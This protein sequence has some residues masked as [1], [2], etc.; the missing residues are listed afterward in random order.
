MEAG[1]NDVGS[2]VQAVRPGLGHPL[3]LEQIHLDQPFAFDI[4]QPTRLETISRS[5]QGM[6]CLRE[7]NL[8]GHTMGFHPGGRVHRIAPEV[9]GEFLL[10]DHPSNHRTGMEPNP[11]LQGLTR[12]A[13]MTCNHLLH[14]ERHF[15]HLLSM[16]KAS[17]RHT[18]HRHVSITNGFDFLGLIHTETK[19]GGL[20]WTV[21]DASLL[22]ATAFDDFS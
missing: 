20:A 14:P 22:L 12:M 6:G 2:G 7:L 10:A 1:E 21:C 15:R 8:A 3:A 9:I 16:I 18:G 5:E 17:D 11:D 13:I 19:S 4:D